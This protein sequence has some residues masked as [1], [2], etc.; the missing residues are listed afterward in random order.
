MS[1]NMG[2]SRNLRKSFNKE[3]QESYS[4]VQI[5]NKDGSLKLLV[6]EE[7]VL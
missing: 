3:F 6:Q 7:E 5:L 1:K 2:L 4:K